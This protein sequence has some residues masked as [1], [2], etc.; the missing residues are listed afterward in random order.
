MSH[1]LML[2][3]R[4]NSSNGYASVLVHIR[5]FSLRSGLLHLCLLD[6]LSLI[7]SSWWH[8]RTRRYKGS[9]HGNRDTKDRALRR[10]AAIVC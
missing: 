4:L 2:G 7:L 6:Q 10:V 5:T 1:G 9:L 8:T 3:E